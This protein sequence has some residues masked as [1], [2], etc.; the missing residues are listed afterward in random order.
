MLEI[1]GSIINI[2]ESFSSWK[3]FLVYNNQL[4]WLP[5]VFSICIAICAASI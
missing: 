2:L 3:S 1:D 5:C 4:I